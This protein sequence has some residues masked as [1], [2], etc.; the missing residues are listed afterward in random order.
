[1]VGLLVMVK[2]EATMRREIADR[3]Q[4]TQFADTHGQLARKQSRQS[5]FILILFPLDC[6]GVFM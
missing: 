4:N 1:M 5:L 3:R 2:W 6:V